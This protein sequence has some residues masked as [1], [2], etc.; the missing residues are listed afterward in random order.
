MKALLS[1]WI[2]VHSSRKR[3]LAL[4][5]LPTKFNQYRNLSSNCVLKLSIRL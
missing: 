3:Y 1:I 4:I 2:F 5:V